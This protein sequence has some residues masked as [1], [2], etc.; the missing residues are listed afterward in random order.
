[1]TA[2]LDSLQRLFIPTQK[3]PAG[4]YS[5]MSPQDDPR[6]YRLHL[7]IEESG[8][9]VLI[10]NASTIL[11]LNQTAA[12]YAYYLIQSTPSDEVAR[13]ISARYRVSPEEARKDYLQLT[14]RIQTLIETPDLDPVTFLDF[15][16]K[17]PFSGQI[18]APYRLDCALTYQVMQETPDEVAPIDE[19]ERELSTQEWTQIMDKAWKAGIPHIIFTGGEPTLRDDLPELLEFA[20]KL[21]M[22]TGLLTDGIRFSDDPYREKLLNTGLDHVMIVLNTESEKAWEAIKESIVED[23]FIAIHLT[24]TEVNHKRISEII[25]HLVELG[26][27][28]ISI[29]A[30]DTKFN[31]NLENARNLIAELGLNLVWNLPVPYSV[32]H[33]VAL[34]ME[35]LEFI[36]DGAGRA[37]LYV[38]P[39][40]DIRKMQ[41]AETVLGN[42]LKDDWKSI[43]QNALSV[44]SE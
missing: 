14:S 38:E 24:I 26:V 13:K 39:D 6:N 42:F 33:P 1:M 4:V 10:I 9:A 28:E 21:G 12:E 35:N 17:I 23:L 15:D 16:R 31:K 34:E 20:E 30:S 32:Q 18:T 41:G 27:H 8:D 3:F 43:W 7:R 40:G 5:Y 37:W 22:V 25:N 11:H 2:I 44:S 36:P 19:V 29:S